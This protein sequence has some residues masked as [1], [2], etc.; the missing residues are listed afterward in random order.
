MDFKKLLLILSIISLSHSVWCQI[1]TEFWFAPPEITSDHGDQPI[2]LR[3]S[4]LT[5]NTSVKVYQ[6]AIGSAPLA[7]VTISANATG[8]IDLSSYIQRIETQSSRIRKTG[9]KITTSA[10][11]S[12]Y[13][14]VGAPLN[15]DIFALK[16]KNALGNYFIIPSQNLFDN[17]P[18]NR[19]N[20]FAH[21]SFDLV[22][23]QNNTV[24][25]ITAKSDIF[26]Y[27]KDTTFILKLN[28]GETF[29]ATKISQNAQVNLAGSVVKSNKPIA[30][31]IKEDSVNN[32]S[33]FDL[34][35]DQLVPVKVTGR[36]YVIIQGYLETAEYVFVTATEDSTQ[37]FLYGSPEPVA[38][39]NQG[40]MYQHRISRE[41]T[42]LVGSKPIYVLHVT[43]FGCELGMAV[44]PSINCKGSQEIGFTRSTSEFF[45][46]NVLV[47]KGGISDFVLNNHG[48]V[49]FDYNFSPVPGTNDQWYAAKLEIG[50]FVPVGSPS[51]ISNRNYSF[52]IGIINGNA[53]TSTRYGYFSAFSTLFLGDDFTMCEGDNQILDAGAGKENYQ[54][55]TGQ[56]SQTIEVNQPGIY[57]VETIKENCRLRDT[58]KVNTRTGSLDLGPDPSICP[59]E[60]ANIDAGPN[61]SYN[62]S[63]GSKQSTLSTDSAGIYWAQVS[64]FTGCK[65]ADTIQVFVKQAAEVDLGADLL[66]CPNQPAT[67]DAFYPD[68][69]YTWSDGSDQP[70]LQVL[71]SGIYWV[72]V[73][74]NDCLIRDSVWVENYPGPWQN[75]VFGSVSVC[76]Y[77]E[78][79]D[80]KVYPGTDYNY[81][82]MVEGGILSSE[83]GLSDIK[84]NWLDTN[85][86][87]A[88][89]VLI[90]DSIGCWSDT[91]KMEVNINVQ[92]NPEKP[93]GP[94]TLC[95]NFAGENE[96]STSYTNGSEYMWTLNAGNF[97]DGQGTHQVSVGWDQPGVYTLQVSENSIT[98]DTVCSGVSPPKQVLVFQ[99]SAEIELI[100]VTVDTANQ[101]LIHIFWEIANRDRIPG[102]SVYLYRST[103]Q[104]NDWQLIRTISSQNNSYQDTQALPN[105][106]YYQYLLSIRNYCEEIKDSYIHNSIFLSGKADAAL[107]LINLTWN[108]YLGWP[109]GVDHYAIYLKPDKNQEFQW[110]TNIS[111]DSNRFDGIS[112]LK[113]FHYEIRVAAV[114]SNGVHSWSNTIQFNFEHPVTLPN[115]ITPNGDGKN[116]YLV[117]PK[118]E[119]YPSS[120][121]NIFNRWGKLVFKKTGYQNNW[122]GQNLPA[123]TYYYWLDL[124]RDNQQLNGSIQVI[125]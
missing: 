85:P 116:D 40:E 121:L 95:L 103:G 25:W 2:F 42:Y 39:L 22:A 81:Q 73:N 15:A 112:S 80:Y 105:Q 43:G 53:R 37:L 57:W 31:T 36:E 35:G 118:I 102:D 100:K 21:S 19:Y 5:E 110:L 23:T 55:S 59:G 96:Y 87:A 51:L 58:I 111:S 13:Y 29:S 94:D 108:P 34:L 9:L 56:N 99:D 33:C 92:L 115:V 3:V 65:A 77:V 91:L 28:K 74:F 109:G 7:T 122:Q 120:Q 90:Q 79:V 50:N 101:D 24:V 75:Q 107:N 119:L 18:P 88:V 68:A 67:L 76:P 123:G 10:P 44:L 12:C 17:G 48:N 86:E 98:A 113:G 114:S 71:D 125:R 70:V 78:E 11:A 46:L 26:G 27:A 20:P 38:L 89:K 60:T 47:R 61:F 117:I 124:N 41:F 6:P 8:T 64:D 49:I 32:A 82:W 84:V 93:A 45:A 52:Q 83:Q 66:K 106:Q 62:W 97:L 4:A 104:S 16:G 63:T 1:D 69:S 14:E 30:I 72:D 54:W